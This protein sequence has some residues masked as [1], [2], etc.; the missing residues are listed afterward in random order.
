MKSTINEHNKFQKFFFTEIF[1]FDFFFRR[2]EKNKPK[3]R[4]N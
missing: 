4:E 3:L 2:I 1:Y